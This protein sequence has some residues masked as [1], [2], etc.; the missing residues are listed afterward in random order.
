[1]TFRFV[2]HESIGSGWSGRSCLMV[3][4]VVNVQYFSCYLLHC[5]CFWDLDCTVAFTHL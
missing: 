2:H 3:M 1:M 5:K 4:I